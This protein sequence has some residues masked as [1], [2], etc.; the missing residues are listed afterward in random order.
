M[1]DDHLGNETS[2]SAELTETGVKASAKSR[3]VSSLD[4]LLGG[5]VDIGSAWLEGIAQRRRARDEGERQIIAAAVQYGLDQMKTDDEFA[6]RAFEGHFKKVARQ[7]L[8]KDAV[9]AEAIEDLR[10]NPPSDE[11]AAT[12]P[13]TVA[14]E[15]MDS[16]ERYAEAASTEELRQRWGRVLSA[17]I[18]RPGTFGAKVLRATDEL[19]GKT[20]KLFERLCTFK[21]RESAISKALVGDLSFPDRMALI[22][23][24][25]I[26]DP[27]I[28]GHIAMLSDATLNDGSSIWLLDLGAF[29]I[30]YRKTC[31]INYSV[32]GPL[33]FH[34][35][36]A[37][38]PAYI[39]TDVGL[40]LS[41]ILSRNEFEVFKAQAK[42]L[43][44]WV[45]D[46]ELKLF[47][48]QPGGRILGV[49][50]SVLN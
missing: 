4:R 47:A 36:R 17:E 22:S 41:S 30:G 50:P 24:G 42:I 8:N 21:V 38:I 2:I 11:E 37:G 1:A 39:L 43:K 5:A 3:A 40:A 10:Q 20:A 46:G 19:D 44:D 12:G 16:F 31:S 6:K 15:F 18:R 26:A 14:E 48:V 13:A 7:Q 34:E 49:D 25:L 27:G 28:S 29:A 9:V 45:P 33:V 23:A 35:G 32:E